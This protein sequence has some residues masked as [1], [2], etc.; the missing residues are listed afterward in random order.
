MTAS[1]ISRH[2]STP[3][4]LCLLVAQSGPAGL[5]SPSAVAAAELAV[6]ELNAGGGILGRHVEFFAKDCGRASGQLALEAVEDRGAEAMIGMFP[7]YARADVTRALAGRI[8][9]LYTP[10]FE[11]GE[12]SPDVIATGETTEDLL[13]VALRVISEK[14]KIRKVF[15]CGSNYRWPRES[16]AV[17]RRLIAAAGGEVVGEAFQR[18]GD[19]DYSLVLENLKSSGADTVIPMFLGLDSVSFNRA[20]AE[21]GLA[22]RITRC[23]PGFDETMLYGLGPDDTENLF[24]ASSYFANQRSRNN[25]L[26]LESYYNH[27]GD[28]PP[29]VNAYGQSVY[30][31]IY[32]LAALMEQ[33]RSSVPTQLRSHLGSVLPGRSARN[34]SEV[35]PVGARASILIAEAQGYD[36][37]II[38]NE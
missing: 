33:S 15:L 1:L 3:M 13:R 16:F 7:S 36:L 29:P 28:S 22:G 25:G 11:G 9:F 6:T 5:W 35:R 14:R 32:N 19:C 2:S 27:F 12:H 37:N 26:F 34:G 17:A 4:R 24:A 30:E 18:L 10:Q 23:I 38:A 21:A 8:P 20:F 31:G